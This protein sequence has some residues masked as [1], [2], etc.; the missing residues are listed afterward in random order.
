MN[1]QYYI[2]Y[3]ISLCIFFS[4]L[5]WGQAQNIPAYKGFV[6]DYVGILS[7]AQSASLNTFLTE[8]AEAS[9]NEIVIAILNLPEGETIDDYTFQIAESWGIGREEN[10]NG[11]LVALYINARQ[12]RI[13][14]GYG[15]EGAIPDLASYNVIQKDMIPFFR[16]Q[17]YYQGLQKGVQSLHL[18]ASDEYSDTM[19][20]RYYS[21]SESRSRDGRGGFSI[22]PIIV[23]IFL[24]VLFF[25]NRGGGGGNGGRRY[26]GRGYYGG[27][28]YWW[29]GT[30]GGGSSSWG[31]GG[32]SGGGFSGGGSFGGFGGGSFGGGGSSGSW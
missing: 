20:K 32:W 8:Q 5:N 11:V 3:F 1:E 12:V 29:G 14:V 4:Q 15:L 6:N 27:G 16:N 2:K 31:G 7:D 13:E 19:R 21:Q 24:L 10:D 22:F 28:P 18:L 17:D 25:N 26:R 30:V 23:I 9:S